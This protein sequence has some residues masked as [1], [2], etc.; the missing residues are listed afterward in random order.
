MAKT[1]LFE[2]EHGDGVAGKLALGTGALVVDMQTG[3]CLW[4]AK[5]TDVQ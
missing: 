3:W 5:V 1:V 2:G 4:L